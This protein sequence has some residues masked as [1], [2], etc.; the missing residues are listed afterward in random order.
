MSI[1]P[2][3]KKKSLRF[4]VLDGSF[5]SIMVGFGES[6]FSAF[7]IFLHATNTQ[8]ALLG[9]LPQML[10]SVLQLFSR[11]L[12]LFFASRKKFV[13]FSATCQ[14]LMHVFIAGAYFF[15][16]LSV[17]ILIA[18]VALYLSFAMV[19]GPVWSSWMGDLVNEEERGM[20]FGRRNKICGFASFVS[21][22]IAG[23]ILQEVSGTNKYYGFLVL[24]GIALVA[25]LISVSYLARKTDPPCDLPAKNPYP[26]FS[27][28]SEVTST[29]YGFFVMFLWFINFAVFLSGPFFAPY[30]L[31]HLHL[32]YMEFTLVTASTIIA[33]LLFMPIWGKAAD[34]YGTRKLLVLS[35]ILI[36]PVPALW[37]FGSAVWYLILIQLYSGFVWA[38]FELTTFNFLFDTTQP[39]KRTSSIAYYNVLNGVFLFLGSL[40]GTFLISIDEGV[41]S[42]SYLFVFLVSS[43]LRG[44]ACI[45]FLHRLKEVRNV[46]PVRYQDLLLN[47]LTVMPTMGVINQ[48]VAITQE[49]G[50]KI[51]MRFKDIDETVHHWLWQSKQR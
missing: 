24:F 35:A 29:N 17:P 27:F 28:L 37:L 46:A 47:V 23:F 42:S 19:P 49:T 45:C 22:L 36:V 16:A 26:F 1:S 34:T 18:C 12:L 2:D 44:I 15:D 33:K 31:N 51:Q 9:S 6:F 32:S 13:V 21:F 14:A 50:K 25:R 48:V 5:Y 8:L 41:F 10:G 39:S 11:R 30:M 3:D 40:M 20:Y 4:S 7:A 43:V 38:G